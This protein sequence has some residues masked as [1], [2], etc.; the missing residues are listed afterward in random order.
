MTS[1]IDTRRSNPRPYPAVTPGGPSLAERRRWIAERAYYKAECRGFAPGAE[2]Q[3]WLEAERE[4]DL[5]LAP[6]VLAAFPEA[7]QPA[8]GQRSEGLERRQGQ[9]ASISLPVQLNTHD[10]RVYHGIGSDIGRDGM[11]VRTPAK[12]NQGSCLDVRI[13]LP[14]LR[15]D[16]P[17]FVVHHANGGLGL[18]FRGL[19][20]G[21][22]GALRL[23]VER[24]A[25][26]AGGRSFGELQ[27]SYG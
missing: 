5:I 14:D 1:E 2:L 16:V 13:D 25:E 15:A 8:E 4:I 11:F 22:A 19:D 17:V 18:M 20:H 7:K 3:D 26:G 10:G 6:A 21:A 9:R 23:V 24:Y 12:M 27:R